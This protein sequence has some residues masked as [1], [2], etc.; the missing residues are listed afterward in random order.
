MDIPVMRTWVDGETVT[1]QMLNEEVR[2]V[3]NFIMSGRPT[4]RV[5][6]RVTAQSI[7]HGGWY[8]IDF[9]TEEF[10]T[11]AMFDV[12]TDNDAVYINT[13]GVYL[14][15]SSVCF[16]SNSTGIRGQRVFSNIQDTISDNRMN[17]LTT[18]STNMTTSTICYLSEGEQISLEAFQNSG[19]PINTLVSGSGENSWLSLVWISS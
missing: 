16:A 1:P 8:A 7:G 3:G 10:D 14:V 17:A 4:V 15:T 18:Y 9:D 12:A 19:A 5:A 11:D 2:D 6:Q 13:S